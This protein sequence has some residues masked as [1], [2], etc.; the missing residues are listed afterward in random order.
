MERSDDVREFMSALV[1]TFGTDRM[2]S[3]FRAAVSTEEGTLMIGT[4]PA[5]W[6]DTQEVLD[7]IIA[8]Q[9]Q[10]LEGAQST[11]G[12]VEGW[13]AGDV[14]WAAARFDVVFGPDTTAALRLTAT[15]VRA[16]DSW[17][18]VQAHV[19]TGIPNEQLVGQELTV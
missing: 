7:L 5:E 18:I 2:A 13:A 4:D 8:T 14:G 1:S 3:A 10:E 12:H 15:M 9:G 17:Q 11:V 16:D 19:S 6:W